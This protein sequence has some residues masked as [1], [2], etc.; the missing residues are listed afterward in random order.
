MKNSFDINKGTEQ[1]HPLSPDLFK[2]Y[3][4]DLSPKL[5]FD[6]CPKLIDQL[7]SHL[8][9]ADDLILL[10]LDPRTLQKQL[11]E[12][13]NFCS[14][15]GIEVNVDKTKLMVFNSQYAERYQVM[16]RIGKHSLKKVSSYCYLGI[17]I[18]ETGSFAI[19]RTELKKKAM[20]ALYGL[21]NTVNKSKLSFRSLTTLFYSL[22]KPIVLYGAPIYTPTMSCLKSLVKLINQSSESETIL[23]G[24]PSILRNISNLNNEKV[25]LH[26]LKW[27]LG[28]NRKA[29]NSGVW[30]ESG[31]YPLIYESINLTLKYFKRLQNLNDGSLVSLAI[32]E[33]INLKLDWYKG[34]E[35]VLE[36]DSCFSSDHI[37]AYYSKTTDPF[38]NNSAHQDSR[39]TKKPQKENFLIHNGFRKRIPEQTIKPNKSRIFQSNLILKQLKSSFKI[40]WQK[41]VS[42]SSKLSYYSQLKTTFGKEQYLD[43]V[44]KY[45]D[46]ANTTRLRIS[47]HRLEIELGRYKKVPRYERTCA[48]CE[49]VFDDK[50]I[51]NEI[52][53]LNQCDMNAAFR[54]QLV[55]KINSLIQKD[56]D[57]ITNESNF[58]KLISSH[59]TNSPPP[60]DNYQAHLSRIVSRYATKCID[61]RKKFLESLDLNPNKIHNKK[62]QR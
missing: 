33:Q 36:L 35:P 25:H 47:A 48:W 8:L 51:E 50:K 44:T 17:E 46:R 27:A 11:D 61:N 13:N 62:G 60:E 58:L 45:K 26:F 12:L 29:C 34:I 15:W 49:I 42:S 41:N 6:N 40:T 55:Q 53:V 1:G 37:T 32:Q 7:I 2:I 20:R 43:H 28:V 14:Q 30:G 52:H 38:T 9:W 10:A 57:L 21:K 18:H 23:Q 5:D 31:R 59:N 19:A 16:P 39:L 3:I 22:I 56:S 54:S 4:K 24:A